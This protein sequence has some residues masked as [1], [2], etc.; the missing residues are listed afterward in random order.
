MESMQYKSTDIL[1]KGLIGILGKRLITDTTMS[2]NYILF[3]VYRTKID[4][5]EIVTVGAFKNF[6]CV[7][8]KIKNENITKGAFKN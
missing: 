7:K 1:E 3:S 2:K 4:D 8:N 5:Q 6:F